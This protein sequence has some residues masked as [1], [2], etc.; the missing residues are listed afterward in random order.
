MKVDRIEKAKYQGYVWMSDKN[1]PET[2]QGDKFFESDL[3]TENNPFIIEAQLYEPEKKVSYSIKYVDG[4]YVASKWE[5]VDKDM[6]DREYYM[7]V[8]YIGNRLELDKKLNFLQHWVEINDPACGG[9]P[10][11]EQSGMKVLQPKELIFVGF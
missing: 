8:S 6:E 1:A 4:E 3:A 2:L 11:D 9:D 5:G 10:S 7:L